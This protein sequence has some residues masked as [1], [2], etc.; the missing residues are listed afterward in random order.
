MNPQTLAE[1]LTLIHNGAGGLTARLTGG[2]SNAPQSAPQERGAPFGGLMAALAAGHFSDE[3]DVLEA[4]GGEVLD[5][6]GLERGLDAQPLPH[7]ARG[8]R[9]QQQGAAA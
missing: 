3:V 7:R 6:Q 9:S 4:G 8:Q 1:A 2:F 5:R